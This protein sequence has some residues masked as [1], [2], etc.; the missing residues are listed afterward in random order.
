VVRV[1]P[2]WFAQKMVV[3]LQPVDVAKGLAGGQL[4][5]VWSGQWKVAGP[6]SADVP[7]LD[8][9]R[10]AEM[11]AKE[12]AIGQA[13]VRVHNVSDPDH[14]LRLTRLVDLA[15]D[16]NFDPVNQPAEVIIGHPVSAYAFTEITV[17]SAGTLYLTASADW[18]MKWYLDGKQI[19]ATSAAGNA[20]NAEEM[21]LHPFAA[22]V[23]AG[24]HVVCVELKPG[25]KGFQLRADIAFTDQAVEKLAGIQVP[26]KIQPQPI[27]LR[28]DPAFTEMPLT[29]AR[30]AVWLKK[31]QAVKGELEKILKDLPGTPQATRAENIL[32]MIR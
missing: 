24:R 10:L 32:A 28:L 1:D 17:P 13:V 4:R 29:S 6:I 8:G 20:G 12:L 5:S 14:R 7:P 25:S 16:Q 30:Q 31:A 18:H 22:P 26:S 23:T 27:D 3:P 19:Y 15:P 11:P 21:S 2:P 9:T